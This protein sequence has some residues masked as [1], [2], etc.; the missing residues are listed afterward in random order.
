MVESSLSD[1]AGYWILQTVAMMVTALLIPR[2][3][4]TGILGALGTVVALAFI[5]A[6]FWDAAL[7]FS[8]PKSATAHALTLVLANGVIFWILV[9][10][11]PGIEIKGVLPALVAPLVF[12]ICSMLIHRYG[13]GIDWAQI[14]E[15]VLEQVSA[16]RDY[17]RKTEVP[18]P[19]TDQF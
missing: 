19:T 7:F 12:A 4:I 16:L 13:Q 2:L 8:L 5:N 15:T 14:F 9:K 18:I 17:F 6:T 3:R 10:L 1:I 11:L